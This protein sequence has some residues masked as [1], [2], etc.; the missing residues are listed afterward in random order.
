MSTG[1]DE[2]ARQLRQL[3]I[4]PE[5]RDASRLV[6]P[7]PVDIGRFVGMAARVGLDVPG[8]F[9]RNPPGGPHV[10]PRFIAE[11]GATPGGA[12]G[13]H[14]SP[15]GAD[16]EYWSRPYSGWGRDGHDVKAYLAHLRR[17]FHTA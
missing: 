16:F 12:A 11:H 9:P 8:E 4:E 17:L 14:A 3:G 1:R 5:L 13:L 15:F 7:F 10:S 2:F 6:F